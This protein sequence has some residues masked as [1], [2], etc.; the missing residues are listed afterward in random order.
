MRLIDA[1]ALIADCQLAQKQADR[2]G[3]EFA[4][5]FY[6]GGGEVS[7]EWWCVEDMIENAP[8]IEPERKKGH[9]IRHPEQRNIFNG[10]TIECS[11]CHEK[12]T[13]QYVEDE[14]FCRHCGADMREP[15]DIPMEYFES[16]GR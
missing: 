1:D 8:T 15:E 11:E 16:G 4:N 12:Y 2:H 14:L 7:T 13:V 5:A 3:R 10:K 6:S 9:W